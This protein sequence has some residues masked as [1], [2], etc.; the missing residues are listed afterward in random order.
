MEKAKQ[1]GKSGVSSHTVSP[2]GVS[3][4]RGIGHANYAAAGA[5]VKMTGIDKVDAKRGKKK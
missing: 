3:S 5:N 4:R 1:G 2:A